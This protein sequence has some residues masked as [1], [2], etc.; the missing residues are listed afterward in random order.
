MIDDEPFQ[1]FNMFLNNPAS[2]ECV[3]QIDVS[4]SCLDLVLVFGCVHWRHVNFL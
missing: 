4:G 3:N 1:M 2:M